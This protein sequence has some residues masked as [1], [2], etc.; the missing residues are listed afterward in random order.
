V[1][2][3]T[4][5]PEKSFTTVPTGTYPAVVMAVKPLDHTTTPDPFGKVGHWALEFRWQLEGEEDEDGRPIELPHTLKFQTGDRPAKQGARV[6][7][8]PWLTEYTRAMGM[9][10]ILPDQRFDTDLF[11]GK[12]ALLTILEDHQ[13]G[14]DPRNKITAIGPVHGRPSRRLNSKP[15]VQPVDDKGIDGEDVP[16]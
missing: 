2:I 8:M 5:P 3:L 16:F 9:P 10:D 15:A 7:H 4:A 11:N 14:K 13:E 6:G 1:A 12:R